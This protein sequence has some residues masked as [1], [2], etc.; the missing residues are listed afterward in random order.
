MMQSIPHDK[1]NTSECVM[2]T[3]LPRED[4]RCRGLSPGMV[5]L[6]CNTCSYIS[7]PTNDKKANINQASLMARKAHASTA[8]V[9]APWAGEPSMTSDGATARRHADPEE[10]P[11][12]QL[13]NA[14]A[15]GGV[16]SQGP[17][18]EAQSSAVQQT[19]NIERTT[20]EKRDR[21]DTKKV[22][23]CKRKEYYPD[24]TLKAEIEASKVTTDQVE[25]VSTETKELRSQ[26]LQLKQERTMYAME[27]E[28]TIKDRVQK[29]VDAGVK[30]RLKSEEAE[31]RRQLDEHMLRQ[32]MAAKAKDA[33]PLD[34]VLLTRVVQRQQELINHF[35]DP[36]AASAWLAEHATPD[37]FR[38]GTRTA[39]LDAMAD[40]LATVDD[41]D[42]AD[43]LPLLATLGFSK[44]KLVGLGVWPAPPPM[45]EEEEEMVF[46]P[47]PGP[48]AAPTHPSPI[49]HLDKEAWD[50]SVLHKCL[51][52]TASKQF[53]RDPLNPEAG[54][55]RI[56]PPH[57]LKIQSQTIRTKV[58][59]DPGDEQRI[60]R[61]KK[62][63]EVVCVFK[64]PCGEQVMVQVD[65]SLLRRNKD[66]YHEQ[67]R[68]FFAKEPML[69]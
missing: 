24:G 64:H 59:Y 6:K 7:K 29:A 12:A 23:T 21:R 31:R 67:I 26:V 40:D 33:Q 20:G 3:P 50:T 4:P 8:M 22:V 52:F 2:L 53:S 44:E 18:T 62:I 54:Q 34:I 45:F 17:R 65:L 16:V 15:A 5:I 57:L 37:G 41:A 35:V 69:R 28:Q 68:R 27:V 46:E 38:A 13:D 55:T 58:Y 63:H 47:K 25:S 49:D 66:H 30:A 56:D 19:V 10:A 14:F 1:T 48:M 43:R 39:Q 42:F 51:E 11:N 36:T 60:I 61:N 9:S 32:A